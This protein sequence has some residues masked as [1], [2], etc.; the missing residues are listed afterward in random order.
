[1]KPRWC[2][3]T[4]FLSGGN[5]VNIKCNTFESTKL[6]QSARSIT[7]NNANVKWDIDLDK[8]E[9]IIVKQRWFSFLSVFATN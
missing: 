8:V 5:Q 7:I 1:M 2:K 4:I 6:S 9:C 3:V